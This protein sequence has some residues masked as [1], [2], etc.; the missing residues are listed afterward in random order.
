MRHFYRIFRK[1]PLVKS[2]KYKFI[3][4]LYLNMIYG[5]RC[6]KVLRTFALRAPAHSGD[7]K[8]AVAKV[9]LGD[10]G[11]VQHRVARTSE[12]SEL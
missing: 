8:G 4:L 1:Q 10:R 11:N 2:R 3:S 12:L 7:Q 9:G 6:V 5:F